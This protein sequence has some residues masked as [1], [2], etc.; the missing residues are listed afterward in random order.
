MTRT[1]ALGDGR[2]VR[3]R[4]ICRDDV[5]LVRQYF[6]GLSQASRTT[7]LPHPFDG[8]RARWICDTSDGRVNV[9]LA[10]VIGEGAGER[11]V[12]YCYYQDADK[13]KYPSVGLAIIDELHGR[14][15]GQ[16]LMDSLTEEA[17]ARGLA[18]LSL[19]VFKTN[20]PAL[21]CYC[22][23]GFRIAGET[24]SRVEHR[25]THR[26]ADAD[27]P[28]ELRAMYL[29]PIPWQLTRLTA[30]TWTLD[31][32]KW[33]LHLLQSARCNLLKIYIWGTQFHHPDEP[34][35][36]HNAWR[37][38]VYREA[39]AY[40]RVLNIK[41]YV[42]F[43]NNTVAPF[44]W[45]GH[46]ELRAREVWY[47]GSALCWSKGKGTIIKFQQHLIDTFADVADGF[48]LWF[49]DPGLCVCEQCADQRSVFE[50]SI[51]TYAAHIGGR[52]ELRLC[53]W[54]LPHLVEGR[55]G[56][57][58]NRGLREAMLDRC[59]PGD[60]VIADE[61]DQETLRQ[62][63]QRGLRPVSFCF[64]LDPE[65]G[66]ERQ[67]ILP[68]PKLAAIA[69]AVAAGQERGDAGQIAYRLTPAT[70]WVS[71]WV[72]FERMIEPGRDDETILTALAERLQLGAPAEVLVRAVQ[73]LDAWWAAR[74]TGRLEEAL[75]CWRALPESTMAPIEA[76]RDA[77]EVLLLLARHLD[78]SGSNSEEELVEVVQATMNE[79]PIFQAFTLDNLWEAS[80]ARDF[81]RQ[82]VRWWLEHLRATS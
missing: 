23:A 20:L 27:S 55:L 42:G 18:G 60:L 2:T 54:C 51:D 37:Y 81:V 19:T 41:T 4:G 25:M 69:D 22:K 39:L 11:M 77:A 17:S 72:F 21:H 26:F 52:A 59:E 40:A 24:D 7:F 62:A 31:D 44:V 29:H 56:I 64:F 13:L 10:A 47:R 43:S 78:G 53:L 82:R 28:F 30:D 68:Q 50:D 66:D 45:L 12:G 57:P 65:G 5:R 48:V 74:D 38:E 35:T 34:R 36:A 73:G 70:Q 61:A 6:E 1:I 15:L 71:D 67:N 58:A 76:V 80:R 16:A 8:E 14:G 63:R 9:R 3:I 49:A 46:P 32:W 75:G 33:Y 79:S